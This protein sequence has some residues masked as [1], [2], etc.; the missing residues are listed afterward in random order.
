MKTRVWILSA[1]SLVVPSMM[2]QSNW[3]VAQAAVHQGFRY[4]RLE[5]GKKP[6]WANPF[7]LRDEVSVEESEELF[8]FVAG[9]PHIPWRHVEGGC[10]AR[11]HEVSRILEL[12]RISSRKVFAAGSFMIP[13]RY[14][15]GI[16][17]W[18]FHTAAVIRVREADGSKT[19]K[20]LDPSLKNG[21]VTLSEWMAAFSPETC[22]KTSRDRAQ[23]ARTD[24]CIYWLAS[25]FTY[26]RDDSP[27]RFFWKKSDW[28][29]AQNELKTQ[30]PISDARKLLDLVSEMPV[31]VPE[32]SGL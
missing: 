32:L 1:L 20:V 4:V 5:D 29:H 22:E 31:F 6:G 25:R 13:S 21:P 10:F 7:K 27:N 9:L 14:P 15:I 24:R 12:N 18:S 3:V 2:M 17:S 19:L 11:A 23:L 26:F 28:V 16:K 30:L 8:R